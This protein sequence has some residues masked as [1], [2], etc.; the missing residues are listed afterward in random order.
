MCTAFRGQRECEQ[1]LEE[2]HF[3]FL[4]A[5]AL[6]AASVAFD[7]EVLL[8]AAFLINL[9]I[10]RQF[11]PFVRLD[12]YWLLADISGIPDFFSQMGLFFRGMLRPNAPGGSTGP[13]LTRPARIVFLLYAILALPVLAYLTFLMVRGLPIVLHAG[14]SA[15]LTQVQILSAGEG[16]WISSLALT[17][18]VLLILPFVGTVL[19]LAGL[20]SL[21]L[22][23]TRLGK[24]R[25]GRRVVTVLGFTGSA[26][27]LLLSFAASPGNVAPTLAASPRAHM[28][29][30][31]TRKA[32]GALKTL[33]ADF[34]GVV[35]PD[36]FTG[37]V[38]LKRPNLARVEVSGS[39]GLGSFAAQLGR[40]PAVCVLSGR[41]STHQV[42]TGCRWQKHQSICG[43][44]GATV[45]QARSLRA[46][47]QRDH[48]FRT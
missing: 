12:G 2:V 43:R 42:N 33:E 35:G 16:W 28:L 21:P 48:I 4:Y 1:I 23:A 14:W 39:E 24:G 10:A 19:I 25:H 45:F 31:D 7:A 30:A 8:F 46:T 40:P 47:R 22:A 5:T 6:I 15:F 18:I 38:T 26:A 37:R 17:Q 9:E 3:D 44:T 20:V 29:V 11:I 34:E 27:V 32:I 13:R 41:Q 36:R